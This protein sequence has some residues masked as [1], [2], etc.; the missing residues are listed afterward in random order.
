LLEGK[1]GG[2]YQTKC[3][4]PKIIHLSYTEPKIIFN[5]MESFGN[6]KVVVLTEK[7]KRLEE[8]QHWIKTGKRKYYDE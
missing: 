1:I 5:I 6:T 8:W 7:G 4:M 3:K 2:K